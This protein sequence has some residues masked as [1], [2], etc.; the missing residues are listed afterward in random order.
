M[1]CIDRSL[2][3]GSVTIGTNKPSRRRSV[4]NTAG[5]EEIRNSYNIFVASY[6]LKILLCRSNSDGVNLRSM[7]IGWYTCIVDCPMK[8]KG[9][10]YDISK[11]ASDYVQGQ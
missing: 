3:F 10:S 11:D 8:K 5:V 4:Q 2:M 1:K 9:G 7:E 6:D